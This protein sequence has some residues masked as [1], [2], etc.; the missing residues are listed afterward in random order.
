MSSFDPRY[1]RDN[2]PG[3]V[4]IALYRIG[5]AIAILMRQKGLAH[6]LSPTQ[7]QALIFL[8]YARPGVRTIGGLAQRLGC[9]LATASGVANALEV[10]GLVVRKPWPQHRRTITLHLTPQGHALAGQV[11]DVLDELEAIVRELPEEEQETLL[12]ATQLIVRRL[13]ERGHVVIYEMCWGCGFFRPY[14][15]PDD[16]A[17]P[18]HCAFMDAPLPEEN[19]CTECPDFMPLEEMTL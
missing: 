10:K 2:V 14:A 13:A 4:T 6:N 9:T 7:V 1:R 5:Q 16:P 8:A 15:H 3:N 18:H 17:G 19:T 11:D 12:R